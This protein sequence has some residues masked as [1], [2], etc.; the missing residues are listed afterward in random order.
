MIILTQRHIYMGVNPTL[1][2][3]KVD[4]SMTSFDN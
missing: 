2:G 3:Q 4:E 1:K